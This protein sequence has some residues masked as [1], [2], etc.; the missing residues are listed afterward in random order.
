MDNVAVGQKP[1]KGK[2]VHPRREGFTNID[3]TSGSMNK[4]NGRTTRVLSPLYLG[5]VTDAD[6]DKA[7][8]FENYWQYLKVYP[9]LGHWDP[10]NEK[11]TDKWVSWKKHGFTLLRGTKGIRTPP[12]VITL[13][14]KYKEAC[15]AKYKTKAE[16]DQAIN[17]AKWTPIGHWFNNKLI[18]YI[19]ARKQ[20]YVP[21][22]AKLIKNKK[23]IKDMQKMIKNE[24]R[25]MILDLD[26]PPKK[27]Y[28]TGILMTNN[29]WTMMINDEKYPFGHGYVVAA[30]IVKLDIHA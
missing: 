24:N 6:G 22:Y 17:N 10:I 30:L 8:R 11:P 3:V 28:P 13:K 18:G 16:R 20:I 29:N 25:L 4:I 5:P 1:G 21:T 19:E 15:N 26:G 12:E 27:S 2:G 14:R 9:Q 7:I 23:V